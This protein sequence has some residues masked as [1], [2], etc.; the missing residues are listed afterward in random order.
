MMSSCLLR[1]A[2]VARGAASGGAVL[3]AD[4]GGA[5][6]AGSWVELG[7]LRSGRVPSTSPDSVARRWMDVA[8]VYNVWWRLLP[9]GK[10]YGDAGDI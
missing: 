2:E 5:A 8:A 4:L 7:S 10:R 9:G 6:S 3:V 1:P